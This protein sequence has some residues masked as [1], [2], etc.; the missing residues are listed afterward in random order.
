MEKHTRCQIALLRQRRISGKIHADLCAQINK[1]TIYW[2]N[3]LETVVDFIMKR[4]SRGLPFRGSV[5]QFWSHKN[6]EFMMCLEL[7]SE[8]DSFLLNLIAQCGNPDSGKMLYLSSLM[9]DEFI[10]LIASEV[11]IEIVSKIQHAK[12]Y[13]TMVDLTPDVCHISS[14][15]WY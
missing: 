11:I 9:Y 5:E 14:S 1:E 12:Y 15:M 2:K 7:I 6:G 8:F 4:G 10:S 3:V 13:S